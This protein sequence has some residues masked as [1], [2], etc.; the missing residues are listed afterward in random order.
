MEFYNEVPNIISTKDLDY[1]SD[2]FTW[3]YEAYKK[4]KNTEHQIINEKIKELLNKSSNVFYTNMTKVL[5]I[6]NTKESTG[7]T[8]ISNPKTEV[9]DGILLNDKD[10]ISE[11]LTC[12]KSMEKN[13]TVAKTE[14]S[15]ENL[16]T[17]YQNIYEDISSLQRETYELMF[18]NGWYELEQAETNTI[19][20]KYTMLNQDLTNLNESA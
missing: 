16:Y 11:L 15:N 18:Q 9:S 10:Y 8:K 17:N 5:N 2:I 1:L 6:L 12:L 20:K 14:A 7:N 3:N 4:I 19:N 13:M